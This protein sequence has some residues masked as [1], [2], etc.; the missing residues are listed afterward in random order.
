[1]A[2]VKVDLEELG[3]L[4]PEAIQR[5]VERQNSFDRENMWTSCCG[6]RF[7]RRA[8][9]Y[10]VQVGFGACVTIFSMCQLVFEKD[11]C[12]KVT[13]YSGLLGTCLGF[14]LPSPSLQRDS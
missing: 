1:M 3:V 7:D 12:S 13:L 4:S 11:D 9:T 10:G 6:R 8:L 5:Q 14:F 2:D